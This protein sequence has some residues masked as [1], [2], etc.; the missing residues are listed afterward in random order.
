MKNPDF[1]VINGVLKTVDAIFKR[2]R[3][4][5][6][7]DNQQMTHLKYSLEAFTAPFLF[8]FKITSE[9]ITLQ[10]SNPQALELLF[11]TVKH[12][13]SIFHSLNSAT[14]PEFMEDNLSHFMEA[15]KFYLTYK[16][17]AQELTQGKVIT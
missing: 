16:S 12:L 15:F 14:I 6:D 3:G 11:R 17:T 7:R 2:F 8:L 13:C 10:A 4:A 9:Q 5:S 1:T